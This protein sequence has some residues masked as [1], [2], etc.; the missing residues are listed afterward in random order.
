MEWINR[1]F[2]LV[3]ENQIEFNKAEVES[4]K[5]KRSSRL[6]WNVIS[7]QVRVD[8]Y[9][10][11]ELTRLDLQ[12]KIGSL[13]QIDKE[14]YNI[15]YVRPDSTRMYDFK[16]NVQIAVT[17]ELSPDLHTVRR[18]VYSLLDYLG[19]LGGLAGALHGLFTV[20]IIIF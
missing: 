10:K 18:Q 20:S 11:I 1:K 9:N 17:Y 14:L 5:L 2:L 4:S 8:I 12:D 6:V 19:D 13:S 16:D 3:L 15:F 7:P